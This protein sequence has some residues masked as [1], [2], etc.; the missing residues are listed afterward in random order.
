MDNEIL[1]FDGYGHF[2]RS[3]IL[4][5]NS[6]GR[7]S[8]NRKMNGQPQPLDFDY[9][10]INDRRE[11]DIFLCTN[12]SQF[13]SMNEILHERLHIFQRIEI[14]LFKYSSSRHILRLFRVLKGY[15]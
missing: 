6:F 10:F 9:L 12:E 3:F 8:A 14:F 11:M 7:F 5:K 1:Q 15:F 2:D 4:T 13:R